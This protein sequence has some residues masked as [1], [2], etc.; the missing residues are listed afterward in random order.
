MAKVTAR[1]VVARPYTKIVE[2]GEDGMFLASILEMP[3]VFADGETGAEALADLD[4]IFPVVVAEMLKRGADIPEP[5]DARTYSGRL[6]VRLLP[7]LHR[8]AAMR[9]QAEGVSLNRVLADA[10]AAY[11]GLPASH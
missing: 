1:D 3:N 9:A 4:D 11:V 2:S 6:Q 10:V 8:R 7:S 5:I